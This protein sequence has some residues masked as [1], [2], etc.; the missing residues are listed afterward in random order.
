MIK[1]N[2]RICVWCGKRKP[3][4]EFSEQI[5]TAEGKIDHPKSGMCD[6]CRRAGADR[7][8]NAP[9]EDEGSSTSSRHRIG[10]IQ[11]VQIAKEHL[12]QQEEKKEKTRTELKK[13]EQ[14]D[15]KKTEY[16]EKKETEE[17]LRQTFFM[18]PKKSA[19][20]LMKKE[21]EAEKNIREQFTQGS[22][23]DKLRKHIEEEKKK[24]AQKIEQEKIEFKPP[25]KGGANPASY[26]TETTTNTST[27]I[28]RRTPE[29]GKFIRSLLSGSS[30]LYRQEELFEE[31]LGIKVDKKNAAKQ[32]ATAKQEI[33]DNTAE[34]NPKPHTPAPKRR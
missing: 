7:K 10:T 26:S 11:R 25:E 20:S 13:Q 12:K 17:K 9:G 3:L 15:I 14:T 27:G 30:P 21:N 5:W 2:F 8:K 28:S 24:Q 22:P 34:E 23:L 1:K 32:Q 4:S 19:D 31:T 16:L 29:F 6:D 18:G 33:S